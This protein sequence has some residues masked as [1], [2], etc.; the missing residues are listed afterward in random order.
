MVVPDLNERGKADGKG[1]KAFHYE[2]QF[3]K[4]VRY[5]QGNH[6]QGH[7]KCEH[8]VGKSLQA[9]DLAAAPAEVRF[10]RDQL[11][12]DA[13]VKHRSHCAIA[14]TAPGVGTSVPSSPYRHAMTER[15][16]AALREVAQHLRIAFSLAVI[17]RYR[18]C[19]FKLNRLPLSV[20]GSIAWRSDLQN[21][22]CNQTR[23]I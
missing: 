23:C 18:K 10:R 11:G 5:F 13:F 16:A 6:Q 3:V 20:T 22:I 19:A 8:R 9:G 17:P 12:S 2:H 14:S 7:R 21:D 15:L 4:G 1:D